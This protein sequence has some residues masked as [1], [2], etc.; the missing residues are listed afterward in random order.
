[1]AQ[2]ARRR[3]E[4]Q[5]AAAEAKAVQVL[6]AG[7][8]PEHPCVSKTNWKRTNNKTKKQNIIQMNLY[9]EPTVTFFVF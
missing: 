3:P 2:Q 4:G 7:S 8:R 9:P 1:M 6:P 5:E